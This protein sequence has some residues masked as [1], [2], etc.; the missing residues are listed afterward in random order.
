[1]FEIATALS[2]VSWIVADLVS[3]AVSAVMAVLFSIATAIL[4]LDL[5]GETDQEP[6]TESEST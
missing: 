6:E 1:M 4:Y 2:G 3:G 5:G